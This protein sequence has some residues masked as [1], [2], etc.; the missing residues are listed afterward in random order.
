MEV[1]SGWRR[2]GK[3][4]KRRRRLINLAMRMSSRLLSV[5]NWG[6]SFCTTCDN[7]PNH[8]VSKD[9]SGKGKR[10]TW[11]KYGTSSQH[12]HHLSI[13]LPLLLHS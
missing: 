1:V 9:K 3:E 7:G 4:G 13:P 6:T 11:A 2:R 8:R 12:K 5:G 10:A